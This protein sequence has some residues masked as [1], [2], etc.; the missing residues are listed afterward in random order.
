MSDTNPADTAPTEESRRT[1]LKSKT[2]W[3]N[4][5]AMLS[6]LIPAVQQFIADNPESAVA[7]L[8]ALNVLVRFATK[9]KVNIFGENTTPPAGSLMAFLVAGAAVGSGLALPSCSPSF[10]PKVEVKLRDPKSGAEAALSYRPDKKVRGGVT[11]PVYDAET[12]ELLGVTDAK[13]RTVNAAK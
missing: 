1:I 13:F 7:V 12:G 6:V 2:F 5:L 11:V 8:G 10:R 3:L 9:G 4:V